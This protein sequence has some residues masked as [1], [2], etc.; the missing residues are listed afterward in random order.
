MTDSKE[1][2]VA[3]MPSLQALAEKAVTA[4]VAGV[5]AKQHYSTTVLDV[6]EIFAPYFL[7]ASAQGGENKA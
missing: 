3:E 7:Y 1:A 6:M 5:N 4:V 2:I